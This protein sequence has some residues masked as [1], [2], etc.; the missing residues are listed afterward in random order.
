MLGDCANCKQLGWLWDRPR[1][2]S[3]SSPRFW[4]TRACGHDER[5]RCD[6]SRPAGRDSYTHRHAESCIAQIKANIGERIV[7]RCGKQTVG[8]AFALFAEVCERCAVSCGKAGAGQARSCF[9]SIQH[10]RRIH[11]REWL[12]AREQSKGSRFEAD[13]CCAVIVRVRNRSSRQAGTVL[14]ALCTVIAF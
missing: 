8:K 11:R 9:Q 1:H 12:R 7:A 2:Y 13:L 14:S 6:Q 4:R 3:T 5:I 10:Q